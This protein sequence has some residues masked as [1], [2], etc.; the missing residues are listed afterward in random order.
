M[1]VMDVCLFQWQFEIR[2]R[3]HGPWFDATGA[4]AKAC[5]EPLCLFSAG[6]QNAR[7]P[8]R[9][10]GCLLAHASTP[11]R[12][13]DHRP[14]MDPT[15]YSCHCDP[16]LA[17]AAA[18]LP[19]SVMAD[20]PWP[21]PASQPDWDH[22]CWTEAKPTRLRPLSPHPTSALRDLPAVPTLPIQ[23]VRRNMYQGVP[24]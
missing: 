14:S 1:P 2:R 13:V 18:L 15:Q 24:P 3:E 11:W 19:T 20:E 5:M 16:H 22:G 10:H 23:D 12:A 9:R 17:A 4:G 6:G 21:Q 8:H 7:V